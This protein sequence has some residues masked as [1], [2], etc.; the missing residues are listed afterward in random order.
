VDDGRPES[1]AR[2]FD[3]AAHRDAT[4]FHALVCEVL[5]EPVMRHTEREFLHQDVRDDGRVQ[6]PAREE[7]LGSLDAEH[8]G[9]V[10][11]GDF[12]LGRTLD[13]NR[14]A[15]ATVDE[16][17]GF[18]EADSLCR[19]LELSVEN[20]EGRPRQVACE[21]IPAPRPRRFGLRFRRLGRG[22]LAGLV[23]CLSD[24]LIEL[25]LQLLLR[26]EQVAERQLQ[27]TRLAALCLVAVD[28]AFEQL[29]FVRQVDDGLAE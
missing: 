6:H 4:E 25:L 26:R 27:L 19:L 7:R 14:P 28:A 17:E 11:P 1:I 2:F 16:V 8:R 5:L 29:V 24:G 20:V 12:V 23:I 9:T 3:I 13:E 21:P 22:A 18:I 15:P 10:F